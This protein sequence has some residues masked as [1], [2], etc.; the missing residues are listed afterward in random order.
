MA[1]KGYFALLFVLGVVVCALSPAMVLAQ[2]TKTK[3]HKQY[4]VG[5][6]VGR[7]SGLTVKMKFLDV[8]ERFH[9]SS[10]SVDVNLTTNFDDNFLWSAHIL[11]ERYLQESPLKLFIGPGLTA[12]VDGQKAFWGVSG[13]IG[14]LFTKGPYEV[15]L[16]GMPRLFLMPDMDGRIEAATGIRIS[17]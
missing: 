11:R 7:I 16:Q 4:S 8:E 17:I 13:T 9:S 10:P 12:G 14:F 2:T 1:Q 6:L 15:F 5:V 3:P